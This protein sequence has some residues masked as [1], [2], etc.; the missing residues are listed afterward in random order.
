[1]RT[2]EIIEKLNLMHS[3]DLETL[4]DTILKTKL[5]DNNLGEAKVL[6]D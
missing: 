1:M 3:T 5:V 2:N 4:F 6:N